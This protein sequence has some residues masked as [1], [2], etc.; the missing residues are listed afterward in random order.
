MKT[1][2]QNKK[3]LVSYLTK[4]TK[5]LCVKPN[6]KYFITMISGDNFIIINDDYSVTKYSIKSTIERYGDNSK[7]VM[8]H[9]LFLDKKVTTTKKSKETKLLISSFNSLFSTLE[10]SITRVS[11]SNLVSEYKIFSKINKTHE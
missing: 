3:D 11:L 5:H 4:T 8:K 9:I 2:E 10:D 7:N 1:T 6:G